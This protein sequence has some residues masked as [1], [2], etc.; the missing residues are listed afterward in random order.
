[1][2]KLHI[3]EIIIKYDIYGIYNAPRE[4]IKDIL[5]KVAMI[6]DGRINIR[7]QIVMKLKHMQC[8]VSYF[9]IAINPYGDVYSCCL[10]AQ[11]GETNGYKLGNIRNAS[12]AEIWEKSKKLRYSLRTKGVQCHYCNYTD[13]RLNMLLSSKNKENKK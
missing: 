5:K 1:M 13:Y 12:F 11:P 10:G 4:K 7:E 8:F 9:K 6:K 3:D 2:L